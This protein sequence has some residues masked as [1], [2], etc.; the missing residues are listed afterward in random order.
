[1]MY[2]VITLASALLAAAAAAQ[3]PAPSTAPPPSRLIGSIE[4]IDPARGELLVTSSRRGEPPTT[5]R[6]PANVPVIRYGRARP[7]DLRVG[8]EIT[9]TGVAVQ[10]LAESVEVVP[11]GYVEAQDPRVR[12]P[13]PAPGQPVPRAPAGPRMPPNVRVKGTITHL[14]PLTVSLGEGLNVQVAV[15]PDTKFTRLRTVKLATARRGEPV[16]VSGTSDRGVFVATRVQVGFEGFP[17]AP[18]RLRPAVENRR[19]R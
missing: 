13:Q 16:V 10:V 15:R 14:R 1:M 11:P 3:G 19:R 7:A 12:R 5:V 17:L 4:A 9:L 18:G 2:R 8:D 6:V